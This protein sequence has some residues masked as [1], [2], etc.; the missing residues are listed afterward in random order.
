MP[1]AETQYTAC[2]DGT[3][4]CYDC[5]ARKIRGHRIANVKEAIEMCPEAQK[6]LSW[7]WHR[8]GWP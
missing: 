5:G 8:V 1:D 3:A 2:Y 7:H 4:A 6:I